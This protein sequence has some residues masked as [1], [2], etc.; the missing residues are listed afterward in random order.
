MSHTSCFLL[1]PAIFSWQVAG[2]P[3]P[4]CSSETL[5]KLGAS[6]TLTLQAKLPVSSA[7]HL[8]AFPPS[9]SLTCPNPSSLG[10]L[11]QTYPSAVLHP[12]NFGLCSQR[13][14]NPLQ[15]RE[16]ARVND[17]LHLDPL[18]TLCGHSTTKNTRLTGISS[19]HGRYHYSLETS[20]HNHNS[21]GARKR[22][23]RYTY[24]H[25]SWRLIGTLAR[26]GRG[27]R[28]KETLDATC[29]VPA[30]SDRFWLSYW[31]DFGELEPVASSPVIF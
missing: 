1:P 5:A 10:L 29:W 14:L 23:E 20:G 21:R 24:T 12:K 26:T 28:R 3:A 30:G 31:C 15:N 27:E 18:Y 2:M 9:N 22:G 13:K 17:S 19:L 6:R 4:L 8:I 25:P 7:F 11:F 16:E